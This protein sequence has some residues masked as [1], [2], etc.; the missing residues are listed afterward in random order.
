MTSS[1][2]RVVTASAIGLWISVVIRSYFRSSQSS[3]LRFWARGFG[4]RRLFGRGHRRTPDRGARRRWR[5]G[6]WVTGDDG[7]DEAHLVRAQ[8]RDL[9]GKGL[10]VACAEGA[11]SEA[12]A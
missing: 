4:A 1:S 10:H 8:K 9:I 2:E 7:L 12:R 5:P 11:T 3:F 6:G